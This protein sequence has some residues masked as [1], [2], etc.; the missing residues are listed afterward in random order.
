MAAQSFET[1]SPPSIL[2]EKPGRSLIDPVWVREEELLGLVVHPGDRIGVGVGG[3]YFL[4]EGEYYPLKKGGW[5]ANP[6]TPC[7][8]TLL[9][10]LAALGEG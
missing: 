10:V 3:G 8:P 4:R 6:S 7:S 1:H 2:V 5:L 9:L